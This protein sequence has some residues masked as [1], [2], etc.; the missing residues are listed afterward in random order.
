MV[1]HHQ[2]EGFDKLRLYS[3]SSDYH[4]RLTGEYHRT[5]GNSPDV[6]FEF[7]ILQIIKKFLAEATFAAEKFNILVG[8][9]QLVDIFHHLLKTCGD[10]ETS[11]IGIVAVENVKIYYSV[12]DTRLEVSVAHS[13]LVIVAE[14]SQ[15][16]FYVHNFASCR[17]RRISYIR[18][19]I[20]LL[21]PV[22]NKKNEHR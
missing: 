22:V 15:I 16:L 1:Y 2:H 5:L 9:L 6:A 13:Q 3:G 17:K 11:V 19:S 4:Q 14:H 20:S 10:S 7:E 8:K 12:A 21:P 18:F